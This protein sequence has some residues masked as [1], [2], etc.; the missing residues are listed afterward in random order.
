MLCNRL[1]DALFHTNR[2]FLALLF[3]AGLLTRITGLSLQFI[4]AAGLGSLCNWG[5]CWGCRNLRRRCSLSL[6][7]F[8]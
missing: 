5:S 6:G 4:K 1:I 3:A 2:F 7:F 8:L